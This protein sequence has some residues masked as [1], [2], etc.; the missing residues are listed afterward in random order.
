MPKHL[1]DPHMFNYMWES[2]IPSDDYIVG[3]YYIE[4]VVEDQDFID[5]LGQVE[6]LE[7]PAQAGLGRLADDQP[8]AAVVNEALARLEPLLG[9]DGF[10]VVARKRPAAGRASRASWRGASPRP[11]PRCC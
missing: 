2:V 10:C 1:Y 11:C 8:G 3:T 7:A 4:D 6:R 5:H 9:P